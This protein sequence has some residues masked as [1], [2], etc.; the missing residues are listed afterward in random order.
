MEE[1]DNRD[2]LSFQL[3]TCVHIYGKASYRNSPSLDRHAGVRE[4]TEVPRRKRAGD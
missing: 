1:E 2:R 4:M 3:V